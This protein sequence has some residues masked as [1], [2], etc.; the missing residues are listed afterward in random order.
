[1]IVGVLILVVGL[2]MVSIGV[3]GITNGEDRFGVSASIAGALAVTS[4]LIK[5]FQ[6]MGIL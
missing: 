5:L 3:I 6:K 4:G 2:F 1:M